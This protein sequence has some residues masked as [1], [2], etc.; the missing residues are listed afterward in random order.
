MHAR[1]SELCEQPRHVAVICGGAVSG[2]EA[3]AACSERGITAI[4]I[5]Q[6]TRPYG[7]IEDGLPRWHD[8]LRAQEYARIDENLK[9]PGVYFVPCTKIG[10][11]LSFERMLRGWGS[12]VT[13][14]ANGAWRDRSLPVTVPTGVDLV[15]H[16]LVYQNPF[17]YWFNHYEE[18]GYNGP[19]YSVS[20][21]AIVVGGGLA[22]IDVAKIINI[23]LYRSAL[24][25]RG[26]QV[27]V[28]E[29]EHHGITGTLADHGLSPEALGIA[30]CT[31]YY[32][33]RVKDM[34]L[35]SPRDNATPEQIAKVE[36][37]REKMVAILREK[38]CVR[39]QDCAM[40]VTPIL[41]HGKL[42][43]LTFR[44][45][46][47]KGGKAVEVAG[48]DF[49]ARA[50]LIVSSI[51]SVPD[52]FEGIPT[53]GELYDYASWETG[54][55]RGLGG[56]FGLGNVLTG[57]G[58]IKDSRNNAREISSSVIADYLGLSGDRQSD[59]MFGMH[60]SAHAAAATVVESAIRR[61]KST[62]DRLRHM[63]DA[64]EARWAAAGYDGDYQRWIEDHPPAS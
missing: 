16:G 37:I 56:V 59:P 47:H 11:D 51:G 39:V 24:R 30:G 64:I 35:A 40:P 38:F 41:E 34:P 61:A 28:V 23:E 48:S 7:K 22:S 15:Q 45:T 53:V 26:I 4:V 8:K 17:V 12:S 43:G 5:E 21:N 58:N 14:L 32:R 54:A 33:R 31:I 2:S 29:M 20:D 60:E 13:L 57:K 62:T 25:A 50:E 3:A 18:P 19:V 36:S 9:K 63:A 1:L 49:D 10:I 6:N 42:A 46:E 52:P 55:L 44:R 27:G